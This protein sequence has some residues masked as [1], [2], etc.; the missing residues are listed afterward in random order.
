MQMVTVNHTR[1][2]GSGGSWAVYAGGNNSAREIAL[3]ELGH[4]FAGLADEYVSYTG[5]FPGGEPTARN[6]TKDPAGAKWSQ[7]LG[8][9]DPRGSS[10]DIGAFEGGG[11][12]P[13][14][15]FRPSSDSKMRSL[16]RPFDAVSREALIHDIYKSVNPLDDWLENASPLS[17][18]DL[19]VDVIDPEVIKLKWYVDDVLVSGANAEDFDIAEFGYGPGTYQV[20]ALAYDDVIDHAHDGGLL[21]LVRTKFELVQ[22]EITW[23]LTLSPTTIEG[24]YNEDG[25]VDAADYV[26]WRDTLGQAVVPPGSGADGDGSGTVDSGDYDFWAARYGGATSESGT[27]TDLT[28]QVPEP[29]ALVIAS[30][31]LGILSTVPPT[32]WKP[33]SSSLRP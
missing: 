23:T 17:D 8:F 25:H 12:Y 7:W 18:V 33:R 15:V 22:Q 19:W 4:S 16:D 20:R 26:R 32:S 2:G 1:Y 3:H 6:L 14:G 11:Y 31:L 13:E 21:D 24:D 28:Q 27:G 9:D 30:I 10:L 29:G 5:P